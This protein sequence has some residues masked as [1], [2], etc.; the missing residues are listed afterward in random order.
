MGEQAAAA[1][2]QLYDQAE[3]DE[4]VRAVKSAF[5]GARVTKITPRETPEIDDPPEEDDDEEE[6]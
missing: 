5:P 6:E 2:R 4:M 1:E 3:S